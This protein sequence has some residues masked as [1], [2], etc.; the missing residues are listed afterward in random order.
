MVL[1]KNPRGCRNALVPSGARHSPRVLEPP[2]IPCTSRSRT[3]SSQAHFCW[4]AFPLF[5]PSSLSCPGHTARKRKKR[6]QSVN[7]L[8]LEQLVRR[9]LPS[10]TTGTG[11]T[12]IQ[13]QPGFKQ[14]RSQ[15]D[16]QSYQ[17][18]GACPPSSSM[19]SKQKSAFQKRAGKSNKPL[20][21]SYA[22]RSTALWQWKPSAILTEKHFTFSTS[23]QPQLSLVVSIKNCS[24]K[25][26]MWRKNAPK[27][28]DTIFCTQLLK[29]SLLQISPKTLKLI[30]P[31]NCCFHGYTS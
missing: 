31:F 2:G 22:A 30:K 26:H 23:S 27:L 28:W 19:K 1:V 25:Q 21:N 18:P 3:S 6:Q 29:E 13:I 4:A 8:L 5:H 12:R 20:T 17:Q 7:S 24:S 9:L 10:G 16:F 14:P 11:H 15:Q